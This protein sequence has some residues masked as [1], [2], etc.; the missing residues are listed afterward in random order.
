M[1][2]EHTDGGLEASDLRTSL[3]T[4]RGHYRETY[5]NH[6]LVDGRAHSTRDLLSVADGRGLGL[7]PYRCSRS[8]ALVCRRAL[9]AHDRSQWRIASAAFA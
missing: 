1:A 4:P 5:R 7:A 2:A 6:G 8:L 9:R 3:C